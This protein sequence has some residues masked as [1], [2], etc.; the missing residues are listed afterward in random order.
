MVTALGTNGAKGRAF[1]RATLVNSSR[2][3][4]ETV[5][6]SLRPRVE[7]GRRHDGGDAETGA[8]LI[9]SDASTGACATCR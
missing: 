6:L 1:S 4:S 5:R 9:V 8:G 2:T 7:G 3:A